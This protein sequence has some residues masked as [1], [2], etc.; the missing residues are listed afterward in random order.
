MATRTGTADNDELL[1]TSNGDVFDVVQGGNDTVSG[2]GGNDLFDFGATFAAGDALSGGGGFDTLKLDGPYGSAV[3]VNAAMLNSVEQIVLAGGN[4]YSLKF[5][6]GVI[7]PGKALTIDASAIAAGNGV[8]LDFRFF[9][10]ASSDTKATV[11]GAA[12]GLTRVYDGAGKTVLHGG[13]GQDGAYAGA[14][15]TSAD[16]FDGGG[17]TGD[18]FH[19]AGDLSAGLTVSGAMLKNF[20]IIYIDA[21]FDYDLTLTDGVIAAGQS[22]NV[23]ASNL[24]A[25]NTLRFDASHETDGSVHIY[26]SQGNDILKGGA[27]GDYLEG[28]NGG[29]DRLLGGGGNDHLQMASA[30]R[31]SDRIDGG[32]GADELNVVGD[33]SFGLKLR[34]A[35]VRNVE[36]FYF[37]PGTQIRLTMADGN[38]AA[39]ATL[40]LTGGNLGGNDWL[41][42]D[43]SA[44]TDGR[45]I[46]SGGAGKDR[47]VGGAGDD[48][49]WGNLKAD[50]LTGGAGADTVRF[51]GIDDSI[52]NRR[53]HITDLDA[54]SDRLSIE[55]DELP[56]PSAVDQ[57]VTGATLNEAS[58][59]ADLASALPAAH[60]KARHAVIVTA[61]SG[62]LA[63]HSYLV[64]DGNHTAGYQA[65]GDM[66]VDITGA[67]HLG[68]FSID[69]FVIL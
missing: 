28:A 17:G 15:F 18:F 26:D 58:L 3:W 39:G 5:F 30:F 46:A 50:V 56:S 23:Y 47:I 45:F 35:T 27:N 21:G 31:A 49:I 22:L 60:L 19:F 69:N 41:D 53:D 55:S 20:E 4:N 62:D 65:G 9:T 61:G 54:A 44:E 63:G 16:S 13:D 37:N 24:G 14:G 11:I 67:T 7:A 25:A 52:G 10:A 29:V 66:L 1:G 12:S 42:F 34:D 33:Y 2:M 51:L 59:L 8:D 6:D 68:S 64:I 57:R 43:G 38:V 40:N 32:D 36:F 48:V